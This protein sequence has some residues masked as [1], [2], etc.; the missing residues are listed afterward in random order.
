MD[1]RPET[2]SVAVTA[3]PPGPLPPALSAGVAVLALIALADAAIETVVAGSAIRWWVALYAVLALAASAWAWRPGGWALRRWGAAGAASTSLLALLALFAGSAWLP[4]GQFDGIRFVGQ[5][6]A[7]VLA[8]WSAAAVALAGFSL[9]RGRTLPVWARV[10]CAVVAL[11]GV[12]AFAIGV[13]SATPYA[14]LVKGT[15]FWSRLPFWLQG[16]FV[17]GLVVLPAGLLVSVVRQG[18]RYAR[19]AGSG[20]WTRHEI[21]ALAVSLAMTVSGVVVPGGGSGARQSKAA[22]PA[23]PPPITPGA[24]PAIDT[25]LEGPPAPAPEPTP[26]Q[27]QARFDRLAPQLPDERYYPAAQA[28]ALGPNVDAIFAFVRDRIR[29]EAYPGILRGSS[30]ALAAQAGNAF[31]RSL[32]L[33][34][35]L[36]M[37]GIRT[38]LVRGDL[39]AADVERLFGRM[40]DGTLAPAS[41]GAAEAGSPFWARVTARARR[42]YT[43]IASAVRPAVVPSGQAAR[44]QTLRDIR[45]HAWVQAEVD[46]KWL[47]LDAS[48]PSSKP[49][50]VHA[51][52]AQTVASA[53]ANWHQQVTVRVR[54][55]R[56]EEKSLRVTTVLEATLPAVALVDQEVFLVHVP[57]ASGGGGFGLGVAG[58]GQG[59][60]T[61]TPVLLVGDD[62]K[63]GRPV[64]FAA[65]ETA[66]GGFLGSLGGGGATATA[67]VAEWVEFEIQRPDGRREMTRRAL[68]DRAPAAWRASASHDEKG[69]R[70]VE[71]D[72]QGPLAART[73]HNIWFSAGPH[74]LRGYAQ[75]VLNAASGEAAADD[76]LGAQLLPLATS[77]FAA[78]V[79]ADHAALPAVNDLPE[80]RLYTDSP[81]IVIVSTVARP[82]GAVVEQYDLRRDLLRGVARDAS[83]DGQVLDRKLWYAALEGALE[84]EA[85]AANVARLGGH[86]SGVTSTS[87]LLTADGVVVLRPADAAQLARLTTDGEK[88]AVLAEALGRARILVVPRAA[89]AGGPCGWWEV[90]PGAD[91]IAMLD[92]GG[93]ASISPAFP[94]FN[95]AGGI[96]ATRYGYQ[97]WEVHYA[98][99]PGGLPNFGKPRPRP[100]K[101]KQW[102]GTEYAILNA[103]LAIATLGLIGYVANGMRKHYQ[104]MAEFDALDA[105]AAR[106]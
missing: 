40:F 38:R 25:D 80:V 71:S 96:K 98:A 79:W 35:M 88:A 13:A 81:R 75:S 2:G 57:Q 44:D 59:K 66:G 32:L 46:G 84:H 63:A 87:S 93:H 30:G 19:H 22:P 48:F 73:V 94:P 54:E 83:F 14:S 49:G 9:V 33:A 85:V 23:G 97:V 3:A 72:D 41:A 29:Y 102:G 5:P 56:L 91:T 52:P 17:G 55:E 61:W 39:G 101:K 76:P 11:Y 7:V 26:E 28:R 92:D 106:K 50:E 43:A 8:G 100:P 60:D 103:I 20:R 62:V 18:L 89:L 77:N 1:V 37:H 78:L 82:G 15:G 70:P 53:P 90:A 68:T 105:A 95:S 51:A 64:S 34:E 42:D 65:R 74:N 21:I 104:R 16:A 12:S 45:Q 86:P 69:L 24:A 47:D 99:E 27:V 6:T 67:F 36:G 4:G 10:V 31:D 58:A